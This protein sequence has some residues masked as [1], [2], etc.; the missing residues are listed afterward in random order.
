[1]PNAIPTGLATNAFTTPLLIT[2]AGTETLK[3]DSMVEIDITASATTFDYLITYELTEDGVAIATETIGNA[4]TV[5]IG[6]IMTEVPNM[7]WVVTPVAGTHTYNVVV[8]I[9]G[10]GIAISNNFGTRALNA[11]IFG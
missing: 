8:T 1:V 2:T 6:D 9:T 4:G 3:L 5:A 11:I 7:T 10:F